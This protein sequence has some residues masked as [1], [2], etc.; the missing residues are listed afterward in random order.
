M[1]AIATAVQ[2]G[3][4]FYSMGAIATAAENGT[5]FYSMGAIATADGMG[6]FSVEPVQRCTGASI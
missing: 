4:G 6:F 1:A 2:N 3:T 5:G